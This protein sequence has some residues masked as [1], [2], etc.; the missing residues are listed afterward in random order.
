[1][2]RTDDALTCL[3]KAQN[4]L[5]EVQRNLAEAQTAPGLPEWTGT[6]EAYVH[7]RATN[8][9]E[10]LIGLKGEIIRLYEE[11][12][13]TWPERCREQRRVSDRTLKCNDKLRG[14]DGPH[15]ADG[16]YTW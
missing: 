8:I 4:K 5:K 10:R 12:G 11:M 7:G 14:H 13:G 9:L 15:R 3:R 2:A 16:G 1:M 6:M